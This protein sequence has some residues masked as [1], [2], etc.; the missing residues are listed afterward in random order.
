MGWNR[1][2]QRHSHPLFQGIAD[3]AFFYFVH[4]FYPQPADTEVIIGECQY[5]LRFAAAVAR[6]NLAACQF[7]PE[8]SAASGLRLLANFLEWKP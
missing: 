8:K 1:V 5:G 7:H 2:F 3:G 6:G 4:S